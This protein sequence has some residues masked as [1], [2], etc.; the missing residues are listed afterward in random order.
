MCYMYWSMH[1]PPQLSE[2]YF[3]LHHRIL[4]IHPLLYLICIVIL[5]YVDIC[6]ICYS[7]ASLRF[8][9]ILFPYLLTLALITIKV[10]FIQRR[11]GHWYRSL[12]QMKMDPLGYILFTCPPTLLYTCVLTKSNFQ[13]LY[14]YSMQVVLENTQTGNTS[15]LLR[16]TVT[17]WA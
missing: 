17:A 4:Y 8:N 7:I 11:G 5:V 15:S 9:I 12:L 3:I 2:P 6:Y 10:S 14:M 1:I 13:C 16:A